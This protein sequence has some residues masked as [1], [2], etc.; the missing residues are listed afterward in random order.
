LLDILN[1]SFFIDPQPEQFGIFRLLNLPSGA[2]TPRS[3]L[4]EQIAASEINRL[5]PH[6]TF[7]SVWPAE[8]DSHSS[9]GPSIERSI[10][11]FAQQFLDRDRLPYSLDL[12]NCGIGIQ[13]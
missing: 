5:P 3:P 6:I 10:F 12:P 9:T 8:S 2:R 11:L 7:S 4:R 13:L 1:G